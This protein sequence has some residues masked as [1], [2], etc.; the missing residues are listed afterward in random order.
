MEN[1]K[2]IVIL[3]GGGHKGIVKLQGDLKSNKTVKGSCNLDFRPTNAYLYLVGDNVA[4]IALY[5]INT[6][7]EVPFCAK[8][9][10]G[11]AVRSSAI[12]MLGGGISNGSILNK[13]DEYNK[14]ANSP[15]NKNMNGSST[16]DSSPIPPSKQTVKPLTIKDVTE[17]DEWSK[18]D[19]NNFYYAVKPQLDELFICYPEEP[20]L[21]NAVENSKWIRVES[22]DD[23]YVVGILFDDGEP[24]LLCYGV[25][26]KANTQPPSELDGACVWLPVSEQD[27][28]FVIYQSAH[29]GEI[30]KT[31]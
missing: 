17:L 24:S 10:F 23:C 18:Y 8:N 1:K 19:G 26:A 16:P 3:S 30:I 13:I 22:A 4:K 21:A 5:D 11:C 12:T 27:G 29:T 14:N 2:E 6:A 25:P 31:L 7:F 15:M 20:T 9:E 28:Y